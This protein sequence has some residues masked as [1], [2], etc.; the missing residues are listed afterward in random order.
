MCM[1]HSLCTHACCRWELAAWKLPFEELNFFQ[2]ITLVQR[3][4][5]ADCLPPPPPDKLPAGPFSG[6][7][8]YVELMQAC[9]A[10]EPAARPKFGV[11]VQRLRC[12][13]HV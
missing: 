11:V 4:S 10:H 9:R 13:A 2:I 3:S 12:G 5:E 6:Y 7:A 1:R 8:E